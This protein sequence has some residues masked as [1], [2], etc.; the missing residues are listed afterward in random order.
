MAEPDTK[1]YTVVGDG[2]FQMLHSEIMTI[3]QERRKVNIFV[4]DN[5]AV[6]S[7]IFIR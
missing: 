3:M 1:I 4:F 7:R 6:A 5:E 2:G